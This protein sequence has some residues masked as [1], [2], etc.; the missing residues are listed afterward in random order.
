MGRRSNVSRHKGRDGRLQYTPTV[1]VS[2]EDRQFLVEQQAKLTAYL[3]EANYVRT[4]PFSLRGLLAETK[5]WVA[6]GLRQA[7][8]LDIGTQHLRADL[9][10]EAVLIEK[11][12]R[13]AK[14]IDQLIEDCRALRPKNQQKVSVERN[15]P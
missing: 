15:Q 6:A 10:T 14:G 11:S 13:L 7:D 5:R 8:G 9:P 3:E 12:Y 4:L 2:A 1:K